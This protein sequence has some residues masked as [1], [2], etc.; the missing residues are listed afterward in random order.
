MCE[1]SFVCH[2]KIFV[3]QKIRWK[4]TPTI[5]LDP[6]GKKSLDI[7]YKSP[8]S[9]QILHKDK[10][11]KIYL[12]ILWVINNYYLFIFSTRWYPAYLPLKWNYL[13]LLIYST[14]TLRFYFIFSYLKKVIYF[15]YFVE[16]KLTFFFKPIKLKLKLR[17]R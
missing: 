7:L 15:F 13:I 4:S 17:V 11:S 1:T 14:L 12:K 9:R 16:K 5:L 8:A 3:T 6:E 10:I 2:F